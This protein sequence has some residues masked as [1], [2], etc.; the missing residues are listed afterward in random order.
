MMK[1][2]ILAASFAAFAGAVQAQTWTT[3]MSEG[4]QSLAYDAASVQRSGSTVTF[5]A[6]MTNSPPQ[7]F[8]LGTGQILT[9]VATATEM[10]SVNCEARTY[11]DLGT[12]YA[13]AA[14]E[15]LHSSSTPDGPS[16]PIGS[17]DQSLVGGLVTTVCPN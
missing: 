14:G 12:S 11:V 10:Y 3:V 1:S 15:V 17:V 16:K 8:T 5:T 9:A 6:R 2:M 4:G 13:N 7:N